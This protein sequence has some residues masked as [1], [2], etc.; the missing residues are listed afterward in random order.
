MAVFRSAVLLVH[1]AVLTADKS[2]DAAVAVGGRPGDHRVASDHV[3]VDEVGKGAAR[4]RWS[5]RG[6]DAEVIAVVR[7]RLL[8][9]TASQI[10]VF[11]ESVE[12]RNI[13]PVFRKPVEAVVGSGVEMILRAYSR[14]PLPS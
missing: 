7:L 2:L 14:R 12:R 3:A 10:G 8:T 5:L 6:Q 1:D 13:G 4:R 9:R 11:S